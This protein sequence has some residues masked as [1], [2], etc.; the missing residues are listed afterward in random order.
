MRET[1]EQIAYRCIIDSSEVNA[2]P[3]KIKFLYTDYAEL[4][5][6]I[7]YALIQASTKERN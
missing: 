7:V 3:G 5:K 4:Q 2:E 6:N 1:Y